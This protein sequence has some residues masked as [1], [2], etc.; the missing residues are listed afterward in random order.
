MTDKPHTLCIDNIYADT[1]MYTAVS[2]VY[3]RPPLSANYS[4]LTRGVLWSLIMGKPCLLCGKVA[5]G[6]GVACGLGVASGEV[7]ACG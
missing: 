2:L 1:F 5:S 6:E 7:V 4:G 3:A